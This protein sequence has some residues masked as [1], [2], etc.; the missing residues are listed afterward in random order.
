MVEER[1]VAYREDNGLARGRR[2]PVD[3]V[4][5]SASG[6]DPQISIANAQLQAPRVAETRGMSARR[7]PWSWSTSTP[8]GRPLG[9]LGDPG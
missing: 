3:A 5:A 1:V 6:L 8:I 2:V 4:T 7:G 9:I